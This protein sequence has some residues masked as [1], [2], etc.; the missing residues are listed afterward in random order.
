MTW[1]YED[2][3]CICELVETEKHVLFECTLHGEEIGRW[4]G[5]V[6]NFKD[7]KEE[8]EIIKGTMSEVKKNRKRNNEIY[9]SMWNRR[10]RHERW[11]DWS[12][13]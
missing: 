9:E 4:R 2:D 8:Y 11:R 10:Q 3:K 12:D 6:R 1:K 5:A 7:G 13:M